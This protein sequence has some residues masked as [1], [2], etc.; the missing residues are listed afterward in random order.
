MKL[1]PRQKVV[2]FSFENSAKDDKVVAGDSIDNFK[3][4]RNDTGHRSHCFR[5]V[6]GSLAIDK[7]RAFILQKA[8]L[9]F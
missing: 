8:V 7:K 1:K 4:I 5:N 2:N 6:F 3:E 9:C